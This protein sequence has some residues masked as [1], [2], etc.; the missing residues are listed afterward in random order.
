[1]SENQQK[2]R[3]IIARTLQ[4]PNAEVPSDASMESLAAWDSL[5]HLDIVLSVEEA[6]KQKFSVAEILEL[7]SV[8]RIA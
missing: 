2:V 4:L 8:E 1:M 6:T 7:T 5:R 3:E